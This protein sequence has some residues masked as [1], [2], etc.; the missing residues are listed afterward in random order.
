MSE[1]I[2]GMELEF[3]DIIADDQKGHL[4]V[5]SSVTENI[6]EN[7][8]Y[9]SLIYVNKSSKPFVPGQR[10]FLHPTSPSWV[11]SSDTVSISE[12]LNES[13]TLY[14]HDIA[15][16]ELTVMLSKLPFGGMAFPIINGQ[17]WTVKDAIERIL[18]VE[19]LR[20]TTDTKEIITLNSGVYA[21]VGEAVLP[22][23]MLSP[24]TLL[25]ALNTIA[26][27]VECRVALD[28]YYNETTGKIDGRKVLLFRKMGTLDQM[29]DTTNVYNFYA[30][31]DYNDYSKGIT[32]FV[33]NGIPSKSTVTAS[34]VAG[35]TPRSET[36][37]CSTDNLYLETEFPIYKINRVY[38]IVEF[39]KFSNIEAPMATRTKDR[40]N[41]KIAIFIEPPLVAFGPLKID[42]T[43]YFVTS[44]K[45][46]TL[47]YE[48]QQNCFYYEQGE[49]KI[50]LTA[51]ASSNPFF[52]R[53]KAK[54]VISLAIKD[55][56]KSLSDRFRN[57]TK[58]GNDVN[59]EGGGSVSL[60]DRIN[61]TG[62]LLDTL[63][64]DTIKLNDDLS[65]FDFFFQIDYTPYITA[66]LTEYKNPTV[67][68]AYSPIVF[69]TQTSTPA[70]IRR[71]G[72]NAQGRL[73]MLGNS[74]ILLLRVIQS[75]KSNEQNICGMKLP[76]YDDYILTS[77]TR[78]FKRGCIESTETYT[79]GFNRRQSYQGT[80]KI[81]RETVRSDNSVIRFMNYCVWNSSIK[82][83]GDGV[84]YYFDLILQGNGSTILGDRIFKD[85]AVS[86]FGNYMCFTF[87]M[88][89]PSIVGNKVISVGNHKE[90]SP[91]VF[92]KTLPRTN[93]LKVRLRRSTPPPNIIDNELPSYSILNSLSASDIPSRYKS[94]LFYLNEPK[95]FDI[96]RYTSAPAGFNE[97]QSRLALQVLLPGYYTFNVLDDHYY[98][99]SSTNN[100]SASG[101]DDSRATYFGAIRN[102]WSYVCE[103]DYELYK[104]PKLMGD[105]SKLFSDKTIGNCYP[106]KSTSVNDDL[107]E[108]S[109]IFRIDK[110]ENE[111]IN[112]TIQIPISK[113]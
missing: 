111:I 72:I 100:N 39:S 109:G 45:Y 19:P 106:L 48:N 2:T 90:L 104:H 11:I 53:D 40:N 60:G 70:D 27:I 56:L 75:E 83:E 74:T 86:K 24:S 62:Q 12:R 102:T 84:K 35:A 1:Y 37:Y 41:D 31:Q 21:E 87:Q 7:F 32:T 44:T 30:K 103:H 59:I 85:A 97:S 13:A 98:I 36:V 112:F 80:D 66:R 67:C 65:G 14:R 68:N 29:A 8:D 26:A 58:P 79:Q 6:D 69:G 52:P 54:S 63:I 47:D 113:T 73:Q 81:Y 16:S 105:T 49:S 94:N 82:E 10:V 50:M 17:T 57:A 61:Y 42:I 20:L 77:I 28:E 43:K 92:G 5:G 108:Y 55:Y 22:E 101:V 9:A 64:G 88:T 93:Y 25:E 107:I 96:T 34:A 71:L 89:D 78:I 51:L 76:N 33:E 91:V 4:L 110:T 3:L 95:Y 38:A 15:L 46:S 99:G 23:L 18:E